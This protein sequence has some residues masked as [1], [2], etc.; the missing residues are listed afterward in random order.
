MLLHI[1]V[2]VSTLNGNLS[3][4]DINKGELHEFFALGGLTGN[5]QSEC[6]Q[7]VLAEQIKTDALLTPMMGSLHLAHLGAK[8]F[9]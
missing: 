2:G 6:F 9:S 5:L 3:K 4:Q 7:K 1:S 8:K